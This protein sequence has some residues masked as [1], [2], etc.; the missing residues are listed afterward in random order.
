MSLFADRREAGK[1]LAELVRTAVPDRDVI[2]LG[3]PRGGIPVACEVAEA[4]HA[5]LDVLIVR[6][7]GVPGEEEL[8][9]GAIA[10]GGVRVLNRDLIKTL[11]VPQE[12]IE[13]VTAR[14]ISELERRERVYREGH[15]PLDVTHRTVVLVD[16][17]LA[18]G[19]TMLAGCRAM[20]ASSAAQVIVAV[21]VAAKETVTRFRKEADRTIC[22]AT[23]EEL[24][25][26]GRWYDDFSPTSDEEVRRLLEAAVSARTKNSPDASN[27]W[28][29]RE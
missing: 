2:V 19:A 23:P 5:P 10:S 3:L 22:V 13:A 8:A 24:V 26:V 9:L 6:K 16:D 11:G 7:L 29:A 27:T 25:A 14:E 4:L 17:G 15:P 12:A 1:R 28:G 21:P 18:T 20:R